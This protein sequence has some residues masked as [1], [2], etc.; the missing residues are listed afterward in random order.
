MIL[1][2]LEARKLIDDSDNNDKVDTLK[3]IA[4]QSHD[5]TPCPFEAIFYSTNFIRLL[6]RLSLTLVKKF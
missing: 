3:V 5:N 4:N 6:L 1:R 2:F